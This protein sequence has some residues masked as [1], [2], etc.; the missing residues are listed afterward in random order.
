MFGTSE[1]VVCLS[2]RTAERYVSTEDVESGGRN[3]TK[4]VWLC[5]DCNEP[6]VTYMVR[7]W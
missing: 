6:V 7:K 1:R 3:F 5:S 4:V 2:H